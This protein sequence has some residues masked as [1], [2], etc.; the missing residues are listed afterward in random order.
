[1]ITGKSVKWLA[2]AAVITALLSF[3]LECDTLPVVAASTMTACVALT[4]S[5]KA[6][7]RSEEK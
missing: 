7:T 5:N 6:K 3:I 2:C 4:Y 1:M